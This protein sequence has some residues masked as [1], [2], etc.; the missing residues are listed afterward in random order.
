M[1]SNLPRYVLAWSIAGDSMEM[2]STG[3][4]REKSKQGKSVYPHFYPV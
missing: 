4:L 1:H 2:S 3:A